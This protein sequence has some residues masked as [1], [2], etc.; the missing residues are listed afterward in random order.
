MDSAIP[1]PQIAVTKTRDLVRVPAPARASWGLT[2]QRT[3]CG[4]ARCGSGCSA[5][6]VVQVTP[7]EWLCEAC[8]DAMEASHAS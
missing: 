4:Y 2:E 3:A 7:G 6:V 5:P 8:A 1:F